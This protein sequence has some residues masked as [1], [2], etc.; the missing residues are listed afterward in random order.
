[1][2]PLSRR[3]DDLTIT[4]LSRFKQ[5]CVGPIFVRRQRKF[6]SALQTVLEAYVKGLPASVYPP[7]LGRAA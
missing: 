3:I 5:R 2:A 1:M 4:I 7:K 6:L